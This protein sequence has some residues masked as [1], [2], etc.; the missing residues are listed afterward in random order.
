MKGIEK[1][2]K[3]QVNELSGAS[4]EIY[5]NAKTHLNEIFMNQQI[6]ARKGQ[7]K[8]QPKGRRKNLKKAKQE[9]D[10]LKSKLSKLE[11]I[12]VF[13]TI[14]ISVKL[15]LINYLRLDIKPSELVQLAKGIERSLVEPFMWE[16]REHLCKDIVEVFEKGF[17]FRR[18]LDIHKVVYN[19]TFRTRSEKFF[20]E[21]QGG[22]NLYFDYNE[23]LKTRTKYL[24]MGIKKAQT[25][26]LE[27][28]GL[29][30]E[31]VTATE[32]ELKLILDLKAF[33]YALNYLL[34]EMREAQEISKELL[35]KASYLKTQVN[36]IAE[37]LLDFI[38]VESDLL[39]KSEEVVKSYYINSKTRREEEPYQKTFEPFREYIELSCKLAGVRFNRENEEL[40]KAYYED[41]KSY[42]KKK[43]RKELYWLKGEVNKSNKAA[44]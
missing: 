7:P 2:F 13:N 16:A 38:K 10:K 22:G 33:H 26:E 24:N 36:T 3:Q 5:T 11:R 39:D 15:E 9:F 32:D 6:A 31:T 25:L 28:V 27:D 19:S 43:L 8:K 35:K 30:S 17:I 29:G 34:E 40:F 41:L 37:G 12:H 44:S 1:E 14:I 20:E 18:S 4:K 21:S 23:L 42:D